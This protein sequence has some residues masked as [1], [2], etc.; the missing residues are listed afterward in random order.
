VIVEVSPNFQ[1]WTPI[2]TNVLPSGV[3]DLSVPLIPN[4]NQFFRA[5]LAP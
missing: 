4:Q 5:R 2:K 3:L 1:S